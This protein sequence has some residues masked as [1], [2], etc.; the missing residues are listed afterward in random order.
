MDAEKKGSNYINLS[1]I[2]TG[3]V[4]VESLLSTAKYIATDYRA[5]LL[6]VTLE[7]LMFLKHNRRFWDVSHVHEALQLPDSE[8]FDDDDGDDDNNVLFPKP[9]FNSFLMTITV[10][11]LLKCF[12]SIFPVRVFFRNE[13]SEVDDAMTKDISVNVDSAYTKVVRYCARPPTKFTTKTDWELWLIRFEA[14]AN[15]AKIGKGDRGKELLSLLDDEPFRLVYQNGLVESKDYSAVCECLTLRY[16]K[17]GMGLEWQIKL[18]CRV[19]R[20]GESLL[21]FAGE[22]RMIASKAFPDW[23]NG[24]LEELV[25]NQFIQGLVSPTMQMQLMKDMPHSIND[26]M[27]LARK[28]ETAEQAQRRLCQERRDQIPASSELLSCPS[29]GAARP[30][31]KGVSSPPAADSFKLQGSGGRGLP[32]AVTPQTK[33]KEDAKVDTGSAVTIIRADI[34]EKVSKCTVSTLAPTT[35]AVVAANGKGLQ[36][37]GQVVLNIHVGGLHVDQLFLVARDLTQECLLGAD[38]LCANGCAIDFDA[39]SMSAGGEVVILQFNQL[40][41]LVCDAVVMESI[42]IPANCEFQLVA[43]LMVD[44]KMCR[45]MAHSMAINRDGAI[46]VQ[47]LNPGNSSITLHNGEKLGRFVP[48]EGPYGVHVVEASQGRISA[49]EKDR[50]VGPEIIESLIMG[51]EGLSDIELEQLR[52]LLCQLSSIISTS[53]SDIGRTRLVQHHIDTQGANPVKQPPRRLPFHRR[54][55]VKRMLNDMLAQ[56]VIEPATGPWSSP[57]VLVQKKDGST[58]FCV[59]FHQLNSLTKKDAHPLP[60]VDDT[61]DS[62]SGAQWFCTIDLASGYWQVEVAEEDKEKTAFSTPFGLFQFRTMPFGLCNAPSTFQ[63]L[64]ERVLTGTFSEPD[65]GVP[66]AEAS[67]SKVEA[68]EMSSV[69]NKVKYL[70]YVVSNKGVEADTEKIQCVLDWPT[71]MSP[72][73]I[74]QFLGL[75]SYYRRFIHNFAQITAPLNRLLEK[76]K[77]WQWTEQC[78]QAFTLLKT[79]LTSAP[80]LVY[81]NFEEAFIVDCDASDDGLGTVLSQNHQGAEHVVYYASRTL[82]KAERKY[83]ATRKEMLALVWAIDQFRPYLY[84]RPFIVRTDHY[85]LQWLRSFKEPEGQV[86]R[87]LERLEEYEFTV[88]HRPGKKHGNADPLSRYPCHQCS[89]QPVGVHATTDQRG[90][91]VG[92]WALQWSKQE[93]IQFQTDDPDIGQMKRLLD[94]EP[95]PDES[96][97][98]E[99]SLDETTENEALIQDRSTDETSQYEEVLVEREDD[100]LVR[101]TEPDMLQGVEHGTE[102]QLVETGDTTEEDPENLVPEMDD[103]MESEEEAQGT[104]EAPEEEG[105]CRSTRE[106][107]PPERF[108]T[109]RHVDMSIYGGSDVTPYMHA[110]KPLPRQLGHLCSR[111]LCT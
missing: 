62:L 64:M 72:K 15:E 85:A 51:V 110:Q 100:T 2:P 111:E 87:W 82:T 5:R 91:N 6:P 74:R 75:A 104:P 102:S 28:L 84:G 80:L 49:C 69:P 29:E 3:S 46:P 40:G 81:P 31:S 44:G 65:G 95:M 107:R 96:G 30:C 55:E 48:L 11:V 53:D 36:L 60:R 26:A 79:K 52:M 16:G 92:G 18:Q 4:E 27:E 38:F 78:S 105:L 25:R 89:N 90:S 73:Q 9:A 86:A 108:G 14:Y 97:H 94:D 33:D 77:R 35:Q 32:P 39:R 19:Q 43:T 22:L 54:E 57:V 7:M 42:S 21:D 8:L 58:R 68:K 98:E 103:N 71:P 50:E 63:R 93:V 10:K 24:Q 13:M 20:P 99:H 66:E 83:C 12:T 67:R 56:G 101:P 88:Q 37:D 109:I 106:R 76:G 61:L 41:P 47:M 45:R 17:T 70:G 34:W 59:D 1:F 23:S